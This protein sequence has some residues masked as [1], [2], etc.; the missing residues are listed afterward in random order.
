MEDHHPMD[1]S[2]AKPDLLKALGTV[3]RNRALLDRGHSGEFHRVGDRSL[4]AWI[5]SPPGWTASDLRPAMLF[6]HGSLWDKGLVSQ[7]APQALYFAERGMV[8]ILFEYRLPGAEAV[9]GTDSLEDVA[10]AHRWTCMHSGELGIDPGRIVMVGAS[11]AAWMAAVRSLGIAA[12]KPEVREQAP[13]VALVLFEP[14]CEVA[15]KLPWSARFKDPKAVSKLVPRKMLEKGAPPALIFHG[16]ADPIVPFESTLKLAKTWTAKSP[17]SRFIPY[18]G[19]G[20]GFY[21]F[22]VDM[23][24]YENTL[25][26]TDDFLVGLGL[27]EAGGSMVAL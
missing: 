18:E 5:F 24:L 15:G 17:A 19:A 7:F 23:R 13:P 10:E 11:G 8:T 25:N 20:H 9:D 16:S 21:N 22:N 26:A 3:D 4:K 14:I 1:S 2:A 27:L 6:F 12:L